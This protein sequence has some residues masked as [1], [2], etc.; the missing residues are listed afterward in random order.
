MICR[1]IGKRL[2]AYLDGE[3][4]ADDQ[5]IVADHL[6]ACAS[7]RRTL[8]DMKKAQVLLRNLD[9]VEP[10]PFFEQRIMARI[11][12]DAASRGFLRKF[13][14]PLHIKIPIQ[15]VATFAV[16]F[17]AYHVYQ[18]SAPE[19]TQPPSSAGNAAKQAMSVPGPGKTIDTPDQRAAGTPGERK[20]A[21]TNGVKRE[22]YAPPPAA[23]ESKKETYI[24]KP[25]G[26]REAPEASPAP[27][28]VPMTR[29]KIITERNGTAVASRDAADRREAAGML[30]KAAQ[31]TRYDEEKKAEQSV[32]AGERRKMMFSPAPQPESTRL[33]KQAVL[34]LTVRVGNVDASVRQVRLYL[35]E[36]KARILRQEHRGD[37]VIL[38]AEVPARQLAALAERLQTIG[39]LHRT[40]DAPKTED[41]NVLMTI[42]IVGNP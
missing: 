33:E 30:D 6:A 20:V 21:K 15:V 27:S 25:I 4:S 23:Q 26:T 42:K 38:W 36:I 41:G 2:P 3:L 22:A 34:N 24:E 9:E 10:P 35:G 13:F 7:C 14:F 40:P 29:N 28:P 32:T 39:Q 1:D 37:G 5:K 12:E 11:R 17:I 19:M 18:Q 31:S 16:A 8:E